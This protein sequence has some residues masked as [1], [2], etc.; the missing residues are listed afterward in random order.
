MGEIYLI[1]HGQASFGEPEYDRLSETGIHQSRRLGD[2]LR[3]RGLAFDAVYAGE[4][5]RQQDTARLALEA[6]T[7]EV[8]TLWIEPAFNELDV[9]RLLHHAVP[10]LILRDPR[11][12]MMIMDMRRNRDAF[13]RVFV[14]VIDEWVAGQWQEAG[15]GQWDGF[16]ERVVSALAMLARRHGP[17]RRLAVFTSGGPITATMQQFGRHER[18]G[19]DWDIANTSITRL[20][21]DGEGALSPG[22]WR[23]IPHLEDRPELVTHL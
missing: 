12:G 20:A 11:L 7:G 21:F 1:R 6:A 14:R 22:E 9:D 3:E 17:G 5:V 19:L 4:R 2:W 13:R 15:I 23:V 10:R 8:P 16:R 18:A